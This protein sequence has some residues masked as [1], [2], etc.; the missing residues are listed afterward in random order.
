[1]PCLSELHCKST[2]IAL[3]YHLSIVILTL[4]ILPTSNFSIILDAKMCYFMS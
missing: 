2:S 4:K 1:M 3:A